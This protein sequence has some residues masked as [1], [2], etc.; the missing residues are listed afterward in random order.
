MRQQAL[1]ESLQV[2]ANQAKTTK[3]RQRK[4]VFA[5]A[6]SALVTG[7]VGT[8]ERDIGGGSWQPAICTLHLRPNVH[9]LQLHKQERLALCAIIS[10]VRLN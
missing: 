4:H 7:I 1:A 8:K 2:R 9:L 3:R 10:H 5:L 6:L